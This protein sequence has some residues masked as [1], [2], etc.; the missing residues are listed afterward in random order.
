MCVCVD[1][2]V[3]VCV[4]ICARDVGYGRTVS[5]RVTVT[6]YTCKHGSFS[7]GKEISSSQP[8]IYDACGRERKLEPGMLSLRC[9]LWPCYL[10]KNRGLTEA[11]FSV[12][13]WVG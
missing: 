13:K 11:I 9:G 7:M 4:F 10:V 12:V 1:V 2:C 5:T 6:S 3:C 8:S